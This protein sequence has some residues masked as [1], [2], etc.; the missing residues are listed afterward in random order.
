MSVQVSYKKQFVLGIMLVFVILISIEGIV[1]FSEFTYT[2]CAFVGT[3]MMSGI[4]LSIQKQICSDF[5]ALEFKFEP[6]L[7][8]LPNQEFETVNI[9]SHGTRGSDFEIPK[10]EDTFRIIVIGGSTVF[11]SGTTDE[12]TIPGLLEQK[13]NQDTFGKK[14]EVIN[15]GLSGSFST[16]E[17]HRINTKYV[18]FEPD[19]LII[20]GGWNDAQKKALDGST[21]EERLE[22]YLT[23]KDSLSAFLSENLRYIRSM[24]LLYNTLFL[25]TYTLTSE[26]SIQKNSHVWKNTWME[27]CTELQN[28]NISTIFALQP[29]VGHPKES[30]TEHEEKYANNLNFKQLTEIIN[31]FSESL[32]EIKTECKNTIDLR[33]SFSDISEQIYYDEGHMGLLGNTI[34]VEKI[35]DIAYPIVRDQ[36]NK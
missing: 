21:N 25:D 13:F 11:G 28:K 16:T 34:I 9:N 10:P 22:N 8:Y 17:I 36:T 1:R 19:L 30:L 3:E 20:Y 5:N 31:V 12:T 18:N 35:Y 2:E 23:E 33:N 15:G 29:L 24:N 14:I 27:M 32:P 7:E 4:D 6:Y 26:V